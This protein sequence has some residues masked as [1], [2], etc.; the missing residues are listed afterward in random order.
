[1]LT[2]PTN[3]TSGSSQLNS[4]LMNS[5]VTQNRASFAR[6]KKFS[7]QI[8]TFSEDE[9]LAAE[10]H[11]NARGREVFEFAC[12]SLNLAETSYFGLRFN[13]PE[14]ENRRYWLDLNKPLH[15]QI[16]HNAVLCFRVRFYP[17]EPASSLHEE[18]SRYCL[19]EQCQRDLLHARLQVNE[20]EKSKLGAL[21]LQAGVGDFDPA[22]HPPGYASQFRLVAR[23]TRRVEEQIEEE[24]RRLASSLNVAKDLRTYGFDPAVVKFHHTNVDV[25]VG[26]NYKGVLIF[27]NSQPIFEFEWRFVESIDLNKKWVTIGLQADFA[28][29]LIAPAADE[30]WV[31]KVRKK[32]QVK[33][34]ALSSKFGKEVWKNLNAQQAFFTE[35]NA[36][37][38]RFSKPAIP[39][40]T[41]GSTFR[42]PTDRVEKE[43][44]RSHVAPREEQHLFTRHPLPRQDTQLELTN[45]FVL[46]EVPVPEIRV[47][48]A[49]IVEEPP[50]LTGIEELFRSSTP[51]EF[52][53]PL[54]T[55]DALSAP[56]A[57]TNG[58]VLQEE[59]T[60]YEPLRVA[61]LNRY[62]H[63]VNRL[64]RR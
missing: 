11:E 39:L 12:R 62:Q 59:P 20:W 23:Q 29:T 15:K 52:E 45:N 9:V 56:A 44:Q 16:P 2:T 64:R 18:V 27:Q 28:S 7:V 40:L 24:H 50:D 37:R 33:L 34:N 3:T 25:L 19:F 61:F 47:Q 38:P 21:I 1:M 5:T 17:S 13:R 30:M 22:K 42:C 58:F 4:S 54:P 48:S 36:V 57:L 51:I 31:E 8:H 43:L 6:P 60:E 14:D 32:R 41:R 53:T 10:F 63:F 55:P 46:P 35:G 49:T 26:S